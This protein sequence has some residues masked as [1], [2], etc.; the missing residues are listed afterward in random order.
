M[1]DSKRKR[2]GKQ[3]RVVLSSSKSVL[4]LNG[5]SATDKKHLDVGFRGFANHARLKGEA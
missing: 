1:V 2:P 4:L 5:S 3:V